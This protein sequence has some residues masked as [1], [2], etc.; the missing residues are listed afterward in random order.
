ML[1]VNHFIGRSAI[2]N[3]GLFLGE[4]VSQGKVVWRY[5]PEFDTELSRDFV[6]TLPPDYREMVLDCAEYF[7]ERNV[8]RLGN[9]GDIFMNHSD[10]PT[11]LDLGNVMLA[12][13]NLLAGEEL[14][15][16]YRVV[17]VA[18]YRPGPHR[19][20]GDVAS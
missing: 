4:P 3:L 6:E 15:C 5:E 10:D 14:T 9:D 18:A 19:M 8:Y 2:H 20:A 1:L 16:D 12:R 11:L 17:H 7:A 13:R